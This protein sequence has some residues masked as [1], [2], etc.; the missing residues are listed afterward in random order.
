MVAP[1]G[2]EFGRNVTRA[3]VHRRHASASSYL[4]VAD[5]GRRAV[6]ALLAHSSG[7]RSRVYSY[8]AF[9]NASTLA[10]DY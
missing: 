1:T 9:L 3:T 8:S 5:P 7:M 4:Y 10:A 2:D 6:I